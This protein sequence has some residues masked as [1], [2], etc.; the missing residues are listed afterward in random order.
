MGFPFAWDMASV[1]PAKLMNNK[2]HWIQ[3]GAPA[4]LVLLHPDTR[5][6]ELLKVIKGGASLEEN[7]LK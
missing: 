7:H 1:H 3:T 2:R 5:E 4:D 6:P